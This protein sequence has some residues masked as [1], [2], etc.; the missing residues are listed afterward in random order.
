MMN[1]V[2]IAVVIVVLLLVLLVIFFRFIFPKIWN[3]K[4]KKKGQDE[5]ASCINCKRH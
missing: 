4:L 1:G 5:G 2:D 3:R